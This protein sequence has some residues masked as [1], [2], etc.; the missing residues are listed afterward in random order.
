M[1]TNHLKLATLWIQYNGQKVTQ[2]RLEMTLKTSEVS[3][4]RMLKDRKVL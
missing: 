4:E 1:N 2:K 3:L